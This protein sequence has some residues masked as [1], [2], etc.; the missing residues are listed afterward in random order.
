MKYYFYLKIFLIFFLSFLFLRL[1]FNDH[2]GVLY[3]N[4]FAPPV[5]VDTLNL[6][7]YGIDNRFV[8]P[9]NPSFLND[10]APLVTLKALS[11]FFN[12]G[13]SVDIFFLLL[14]VLPGVFILFFI[15][16]KYLDL[17]LALTFI[18]SFWYLDRVQQGH[19]FT[20]SFFLSLS[21]VY[22]FF[23][24]KPPDL[25]KMYYLTILSSISVYLD[26][27]YSVILVFLTIIYFIFNKSIVS[28]KDIIKIIFYNLLCL[29]PAL[30]HVWFYIKSGSTVS[31]AD[32]NPLVFVWQAS[33]LASLLHIRGGMLSGYVLKQHGLII[34]IFLVFFVAI[35]SYYNLFISNTRLYVKNSVLFL[36]MLSSCGYLLNTEIYIKMMNLPFFSIIRDT[37]KVV[38]VLFL[39]LI[40]NFNLISFRNNF[41][42]RIFAASA[43]S[44][45]LAYVFY[46]P[47]IFFIKQKDQSDVVRFILDSNVSYIYLNKNPNPLLFKN[48]YTYH[49]YPIFT[50][51]L[52]GLPVV[53]YPFAYQESE[54]YSEKRDTIESLIKYIDTGEYN[55]TLRGK[56]FNLI[57]NKNQ[58]FDFVKK[59]LP[60]T[61]IHEFSNYYLF[62]EFKVI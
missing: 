34:P 20:A 10:L 12:F 5:N 8:N 57:I 52:Y 53:S 40:M 51:S 17:P 45:F 16:N 7:L 58:S 59:Y 30:A 48:N 61:N 35:V 4:D 27:H 46:N 13:T 32:L 38:G 21:V 47:Y 11:F 41:V 29:V 22:I 56:T 33:P 24:F 50:N 39:F 9:S 55:S 18:F 14:F 60:G 43:L 42:E 26:Y 1:I 62:K 15:K 19:I 44:L 23:F 37:N 36:L 2:S 6:S 28:G 25:K 49:T 54:V 31:S 3:F